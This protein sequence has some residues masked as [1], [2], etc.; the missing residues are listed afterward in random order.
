VLWHILFTKGCFQI[1][2]AGDVEQVQA[3][4]EAEEP[5]AVGSP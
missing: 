3:H 5:V 1:W 4:A 2:P